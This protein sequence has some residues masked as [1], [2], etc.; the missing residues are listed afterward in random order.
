MQQSWPKTQAVFLLA[1][2]LSA[3]SVADDWIGEVLELRDKRC[4]FPADGN[5]PKMSPITYEPKGLTE[6]QKIS[7]VLK[8]LRSEPTPDRRMVCLKILIERFPI[9][10]YRK[11]KSIANDGSLDLEIRKRAIWLTGI[12]QQEDAIPWLEKLLGNMEPSVREAAIDAL[13]LHLFPCF[14]SQFFSQDFTSRFGVSFNG[15]V[16]I[17]VN[18]ASRF[19]AIAFSDVEGMTEMSAA[20][21][22]MR[23]GI[24]Q[25][26]ML[27]QVGDKE[28]R[29]RI[30]SKLL[31]I[32]V[33]GRT[34]SE[35]IAAARALAGYEPDD[36]KLRVAEWGVWI[37]SAGK[38]Q[39]VQ[40]VLDEIPPIAY[41][42]TAQISDLKNRV[43]QIMIVTKP[44]IHLKVDRP[45]SVNLSAAIHEGQVW[46]SYPQP[47]DFKL[48]LARNFRDRELTDNEFIDVRK[49]TKARPEK[50][51]A[52]G[53]QAHEGYPFLLP[54]FSK[55]GGYSGR[56]RQTN[57]IQG[58]G[59]TWQHL[60]VS[61]TRLDW[62][63][64]QPVPLK[65]RWWSDLRK[66]DAA[67]ISNGFESEKFLYYDGPTRLPSPIKI[68]KSR[69]DGK[70]YFDLIYFGV[71]DN[72]VSN[73]VKVGRLSKPLA[74]LIEVEKGIVRGSEI[75]FDSPIEDKQKIDALKKQLNIADILGWKASF[76][77]DPEFDLDQK[78]VEQKLM[79]MVTTS[80]GLDKDEA[81]GLVGS[82]RNQFF[83]TD[84][85]R[86]I[87]RI[88]RADYDFQCPLNVSPTPTQVS[89]VGLILSELEE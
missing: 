47:N 50:W 84:G 12:M 5:L 59:V 49:Q 87:V 26:N 74:L 56:S 69:R 89:R 86:V 17:Y 8:G 9:T 88:R 33:K 1:L 62:M 13:G 24:S 37:E 80:N 81:Q 75:S 22:L 36:Y 15:K 68:E 28:T 11:M 60:V 67:W 41:Q 51:K 76:L 73:Q 83:K 40:S 54:R 34:R 25:E 43:N 32:M 27:K 6:S 70:D 38:L 71:K 29:K 20:Q 53:E 82:W 57:L 10:A 31:K 65:Y 23:T 2:L 78:G 44:V 3:Q 39:L 55:I 7:R 72:E 79:D 16:P 19:R 18:N 21:K 64:E 42:T 77:Q 30:A 14:L 61:P 85:K 45:L 52:F 63:F 35:R 46:F 66:V 48:H 4:D 58:V